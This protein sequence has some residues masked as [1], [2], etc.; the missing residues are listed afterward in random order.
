MRLKFWQRSPAP[1]PSAALPEAAPEPVRKKRSW[2]GMR[3]LMQMFKASQNAGNDN[4][5]GMPISPDAFI[6][7]NQMPL[8]ARSREQWSNNDYVRKFVR[9]MRQNVVG[10]KGVT[11][12]AKA[13]TPRGKMDKEANSAIETAWETWGK[14]GN[15]DV[16]GKLSWRALQNLA[17]ETAARDGEFLFR[18][19]RGEE[20]GPFGYAL[21]VLDPQRLLIKY[22]NTHFNNSGNFIRQGIEFNKYGKPVAYHFASTDEWDAYYYAI[23]GRGFVRIPAEEIIHGYVSEMAGQK[24][25]LPWAAT[26][27]FRLHHLQG[28]EDASVQN[29]RAGATKMGFFQYKEGYGPEA[30]DDEPLEIDAEP[31][32]FHELPIGAELVDFQPQYPN[33]EFQPFH[34]AM[35]RGAS[36]GMGVPY[37]DMANDLEGVNFSSIRQGTLDAREYYKELQEWLIESLHEI[38]FN[39]WLKLQLL[40][41]TIKTKAG[42][43]LPASKLEVYSVVSWQARRWA[44]IDPRAD[45]DA[46]LSAIRGG[47]MSTSQAIREQGRDPET[48][49]AEIANDLEEMKAAGIPED[50]IHLFMNGQPMPPDPKQS[51]SVGKA[52]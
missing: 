2:Q 14:K 42:K 20:A 45:V 33:G 38:V 29:A 11:M 47:L 26:S 1:A 21:Q 32:G 44:W 23:A 4:W 18:K 8:V 25:G 36:S 15:C 19:V 43:A 48:V 30:D 13:A 49:Y 52:D 31:L 39:D 3:S 24:R 6:T 40:Q 46:S 5:G 37:N 7:L 10:P 27:L 17:I 9:L 16:T 50:I 41:G 34:K 51:D 28:F 35:L 22:E 12:Q